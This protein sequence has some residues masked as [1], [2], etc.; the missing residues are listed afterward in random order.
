MNTFV[1]WKWKSAHYDI[2]FE[3]EHVNVLAAQI[4]RKYRRPHRT[5][6][7]TDD[8][9]GIEC[10]TFPIWN[11]HA[12]LPNPSAMDG[13]L[14]LPRCFRRLKIFSG[15]QTDAMGIPRGSPVTSLDLDVVLASDIEPLL[16]KHD[17]AP[18][19]G[20]L[21]VGWH[22]SRVYNGSFFRFRAGEMAHLWDEFDPEVSPR[23]ALQ[24]KYFGSD[25]AWISYRLAGKA[26]GWGRIDGVLSYTSNLGLRG[27]RGAL[28]ATARVVCFNGRRKPWDPAVQA[29]S[30]WVTAFW[31]R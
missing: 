19:V 17:G 9:E 21:G 14:R 4:R 24:A 27:H 16:L 13:S 1:C 5:V 18:F 11:D 2:K 31:H 3:A 10:E 30:P 6:C 12:E 23:L 15:E 26:P 7:I 22:N 28:P 20:W 8:P 25:Q 29:A